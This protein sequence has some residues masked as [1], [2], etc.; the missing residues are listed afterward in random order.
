LVEPS[1]SLYAARSQGMMLTKHDRS[2][3]GVDEGFL[4]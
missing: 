4:D 3:Q 2:G 1:G